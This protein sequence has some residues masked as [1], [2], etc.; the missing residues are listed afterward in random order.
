VGVPHMHLNVSLSDG[1]ETTVSCR[2][3]HQFKHTTN[4]DKLSE[5]IYGSSAVPKTRNQFIGFSEEGHLSLVY[6]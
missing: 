5:S 3:T 1:A 2:A 6:T 4:S